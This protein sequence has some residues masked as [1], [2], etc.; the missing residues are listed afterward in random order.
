MHLEGTI[1]C[2]GTGGNVGGDED[3]GGRQSGT[4]GGWGALEGWCA[5][6]YC[7]CP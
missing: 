3:V 1:R 2:C 6:S 7:A 5:G 4:T